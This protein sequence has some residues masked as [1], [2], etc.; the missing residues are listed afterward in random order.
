[1]ARLR[2]PLF[3]NLKFCGDGIRGASMR[4]RSAYISELEEGIHGLG[5]GDLF[6]LFGEG[7]LFQFK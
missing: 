4:R 5:L 7:M 2:C 6:Y 1:M 3:A